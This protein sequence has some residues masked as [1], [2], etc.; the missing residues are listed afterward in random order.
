MLLWDS[1][2]KI[3]QARLSPLGREQL[4]KLSIASIESVVQ[5]GIEMDDEIETEFGRAFN[6]LKQRRSYPCEGLEE[7][8]QGESGPGVYDLSMAVIN[9]SR[10]FDA[11]D[12][13][14]TLESLSYCYQAILDREI[15]SQLEQ[16]MTES[17]VNVLEARN[18]SCVG[19]IDKQLDL[20]E[21]L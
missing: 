17:E 5:S 7:M 10:N 19:C 12:K 8:I 15:L 20:L 21:S 1:K 9:L 13:D 16:N 18:A 14:V 11:I 6:A 4:L 3:N 2:W